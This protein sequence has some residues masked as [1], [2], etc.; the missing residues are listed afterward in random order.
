MEYCNMLFLE[1]A[2]FGFAFIIIKLWQLFGLPN[3]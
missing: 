2:F 3:K 1:I